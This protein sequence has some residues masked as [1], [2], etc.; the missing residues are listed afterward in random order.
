MALGFDNFILTVTTGT[1]SLFSIHPTHG[2]NENKIVN[3]TN[4]RMMGGNLHTYK[5][6]GHTWN[7]TLPLTFVASDERVAL[8]RWWENQTELFFYFDTS[9]AT[10]ADFQSVRTVISNRIM[11]FGTRSPFQSTKYDGILHLT[12]TQ[13]GGPTFTTGFFMTDHPVY[14]LLDK[15]YNNLG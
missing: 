15:S 11:P 6:I 13:S 7:Y 8:N 14:G 9:S 5:T 12:S 1:D 4:R 10:G 3:N 2:F